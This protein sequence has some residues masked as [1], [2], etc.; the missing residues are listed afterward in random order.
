MVTADTDCNC[1][2]HGTITLLGGRGHWTWASGNPGQ[3]PVGTPH[4]HGLA[5]AGILHTPLWTMASRSLLAPE[6]LA[7]EDKHTYAARR[8][9][10]RYVIVHTLAQPAEPCGQEEV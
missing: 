9:V 5:G 4:A 3:A 7:W 1:E 8:L 2:R 10:F 6:H